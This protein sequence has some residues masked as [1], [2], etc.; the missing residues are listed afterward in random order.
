MCFP[1]QPVSYMV[2]VGIDLVS[3]AM[4]LF[5]V[6]IAVECLLILFKYSSVSCNCG[7]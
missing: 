6:L 1:A 4:W 3:S 7:L 5:L 2:V